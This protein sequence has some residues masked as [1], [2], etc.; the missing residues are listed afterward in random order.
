MNSVFIHTLQQV[1]F[2]FKTIVKTSMYTDICICRYIYVFTYAYGLRIAMASLTLEVKKQTHCDLNHDLSFFL[3]GLLLTALVSTDFYVL[4]VWL[5]SGLQTLLKS[6]LHVLWDSYTVVELAY[7]TAVIR[8][9]FRHRKLS[10][11]TCRCHF[12]RNIR[13]NFRKK[14]SKIFFENLSHTTE[15]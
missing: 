2:I 12:N 9:K 1:F 5:V 3:I 15:R 6:E 4:P 13:S 14:S 7:Y 10:R 11:F 8:R